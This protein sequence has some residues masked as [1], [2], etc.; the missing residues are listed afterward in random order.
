MKKDRTLKKR[1]A[2]KKRRTAHAATQLIEKRQI[3][4]SFLRADDPLDEFVNR[5]R[6]QEKQLLQEVFDENY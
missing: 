2:V 3:T 1:T 6:R 4:D 5:L